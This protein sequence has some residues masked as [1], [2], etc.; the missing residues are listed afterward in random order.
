ML[1]GWPHQVPKQ[2]DLRC[3][4]QSG[5]PRHRSP[6]PQPGASPQR[7]SKHVSS[8]VVEVVLLADTSPLPGVVIPD[9]PGALECC[10]A[11]DRAVLLTPAAT[12]HEHR[13]A[14]CR[15]GLHGLV[16]RLARA[17]EHYS[18]F[19]LQTKNLPWFLEE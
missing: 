8:D 1:R 15:T 18:T 5:S 17:C 16:E 7:L 12:A 4:G 13:T 14:H 2:L 10:L 6:I 3:Q 19:G 11:W 9:P